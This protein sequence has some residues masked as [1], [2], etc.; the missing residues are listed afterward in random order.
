MRSTARKGTPI[1]TFQVTPGITRT[2]LRNVPYFS[3]ARRK[4]PTASG[5]NQVQIS[6][7]ARV[8]ESLPD[9]IALSSSYLPHIRTTYSVVYGCSKK[10][11][12]TIN[13]RINS[14]GEDANH[15]L[16]MVG[17]FAE[18]EYR[19]LM[20]QAEDLVD[21]F[22]LESDML[23]H[24]TSWDPDSGLIQKHLEVCLQSRTLVD[25]I[26][27][28][29]RQLAKVSKE[30]DTL[31]TYWQS[32]EY[33]SLWKEDQTT[34]S[35]GVVATGTERMIEIASQM[36][37]RISD[38]QDEYDDKIDE[39]NKMTQNMSLAMQTG[40]NQIARKDA[41]TNGKIARANTDIAI[42][43]KRESSQMRYI[44]LL[45][46]IFLPLSCVASVFST[47]I[48]NWEAEDGH[49]VVSN[50]IWVL[51]GIALILTIVTVSAWW[52]FTWRERNKEEAKNRNKEDDDLERGR[53]R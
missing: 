19:R 23:E 26:R 34:D 36:K 7:T 3:A 8:A 22:T 53:M 48:F 28:V 18:L 25:H 52:F 14:A 39:C 33:T 35:K 20:D 11:I 51:L 32:E 42:E 27:T 16:L 13:S 37:Y 17:I 41:V 5:K 30:I 24:G 49:P 4:I 50:Y 46:M 45:T 29:K 15:P 12:D 1:E 31:I 10:Q 38:I 6:Y 21:R 47:T 44:A 43:T 40:Y 2:I 9:D